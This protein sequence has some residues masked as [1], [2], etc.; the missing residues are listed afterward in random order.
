MMNIIWILVR[1]EIQILS[2]YPAGHNEPGPILH[3]KFVYLLL[4][5]DLH[6][7]V[8]YVFHS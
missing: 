6:G 1:I 5:E 2:N 4:V 8:E 3:L 7:S